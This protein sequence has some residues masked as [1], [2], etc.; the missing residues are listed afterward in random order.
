MHRS[1]RVVSFVL[2]LAALPVLVRS[3]V[4][5]ADKAALIHFYKL[6]G[7][8]Y[9]TKNDG[10]DVD[11]GG[12]P[13]DSYSSWYG[14]RCD[15]PCNEMW[16]GPD[17]KFGR[18]TVISLFD[19]NL[20]G[21]MTNWTGIGDLHNLSLLDLSLNSISGSI[22]AEIGNVNN[23]EVLN[24]AWNQLDGDVPTTLGDL[25]SNGAASMD[26]LSLE[27]NRLHG[28]LPSGLGRYSRLSMFNI[29]RNSISGSLPPE[30]TNLT[31]LQ[32]LYA[33]NNFLTGVLP[34]EIG[35][36]KSIRYLNV[37]GNNISGT[38]P[39]SIG[40]IRDILDLAAFQN[41]IS[42]SLPTELGNLATLRHLRLQNNELDGNLSKFSTL[43]NLRRLMT[44]DLYDNKM[45]GDLPAGI[46]NL[47]SLQYLYVD[48]KH[49]KLL[50]N[51]YCRQR[52]PDNG[53]YNYRIVRDM[54]YE[55]ANAYC[56]NPYDTNFAFNSLQVSKA[57]PD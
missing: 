32:V 50:R 22:P 29:G 2:L 24:L 11:G 36:M 54:Y 48:N 44:L 12:D 34:E 4:R 19:N 42:G 49:Y 23:L 10:W 8:P 28:T 9:W 56:E 7:G 45:T 40:E 33:G 41:R 37:S 52:L 6:L 35:K 17:C 16:D 26:Q 18:I 14:V 46:Q 30:L 21:S 38:L 57:Y 43:G 47:T 5:R 55:M 1:A 27:W 51:Y 20:T 39:S 3:K 25:N 31:E 15:D 53:K 13:C